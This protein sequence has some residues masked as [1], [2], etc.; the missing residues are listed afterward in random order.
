[1]QWRLHARV[2]GDS[3]GP[4]YKLSNNKSRCC[5]LKKR[6]VKRSQGS[7]RRRRRSTRKRSV[8]VLTADSFLLTSIS[9]TS[10]PQRLQE[11]VCFC[12]RWGSDV[13]WTDRAQISSSSSSTS[14]SS[15][16]CVCAR[17]RA[18]V[19]FLKPYLSH[20]YRLF[21]PQRSWPPPLSLCICAFNLC[22]FEN[23]LPVC[24]HRNHWA[25]QSEAAASATEGFVSL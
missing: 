12:R 8:Q 2:N 4:R 14:T 15:G 6:E 16:V 1:M 3:G 17:A 7:G 21:L 10:L 23:L 25:S 20:S 5:K 9:L 24:L 18:C 22:L 13:N 19:S 11:P